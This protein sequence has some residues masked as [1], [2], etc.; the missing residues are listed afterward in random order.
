[1]AKF[2][3]TRA[4][5]GICLSIAGIAAAEPA[6]AQSTVD[7]VMI[8]DESGS[9]SEEQRF[10]GSA[11]NFDNGLV[12]NGITGNRYGLV[13]FG[14]YFISS[15]SYTFGRRVQL[16][17]G[18]FGTSTQLDQA[19]NSLLVNGGTEDGYAG[20][21]YAQTNYLPQTRSG[22]VRQFFIIT[23]EDR[24]QVAPLSRAQ[25]LSTLT[26]NNVVLNAIVAQTIKAPDGTQVLAM[27]RDT[28]TNRLVG[29]VQDGQQVREI[30]LGTDPAAVLVKAPPSSIAAT[31]VEDYSTLALE[32]GHSVLV[33]RSR[34]R[35]AGRS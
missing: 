8:V 16:G 3:L 15:P 14:G 5:M 11:L 30:D 7:F 20:V 9:M 27:F 4:S 23:D 19:I 33:I 24:D 6:Q 1:V 2:A 13:G 35:A 31:T 21:N 10:V 28:S 29:F 26:A 34:A 22:A 25:M 18:Y 12:I 32:Q 17:D